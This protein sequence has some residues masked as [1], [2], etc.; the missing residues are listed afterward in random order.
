MN[1]PER[2]AER[3]AGLL[4]TAVGLTMTLILVL[5]ATHVAVALHTR[6]VVGAAAEEGARA[7]AQSS[8]D[9][10][11]AEA[12]V[13][14]VLGDL[15]AELTWQVDDRQVALRVTARA[16]D[17]LRGIPVLDALRTVTRTAHVRR[18]LWR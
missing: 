12:T 9:V 1:G 13:R 15:P 11:G 10:R 4:S 2:A 7:V 3:G 8:D 5:L 16:P 17:V 6:T 14:S 18:E